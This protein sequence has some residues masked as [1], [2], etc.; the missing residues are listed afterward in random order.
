MNSAAGCRIP[1]AVAININASVIR[2]IPYIIWSTIFCLF[3]HY[4]CNELDA[5]DEYMT[6][7]NWLC[8]QQY[9]LCVEYRLKLN[10]AYSTFLLQMD[11]VSGMVARSDQLC[12]CMWPRSNGEV[13]ASH[14]WTVRPAG[15]SKKLCQSFDRMHQLRRFAAVFEFFDLI[16]FCLY[17][18]LVYSFGSIGF[19]IIG[20]FFDAHVWNPSS[21]TNGPAAIC[22]DLLACRF[23]PIFFGPS[24]L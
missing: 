2:P 23:R 13:L 1:H 5:S 12:L 22:A 19:C 8:P 20:F 17:H 14:H 24:T 16:G 7:T 6:L 3:F 9:Y 21:R 18:I 11:G 15:P 4:I 10:R